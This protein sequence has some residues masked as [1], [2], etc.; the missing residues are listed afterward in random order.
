MFL[1]MQ[2]FDIAQDVIF[3]QIEKLLPKFRL[4]L[5]ILPNAAF[6]HAGL[7]TRYRT[8]SLYKNIFMLQRSL[9]IK[10]MKK[11]ESQLKIA[12]IKFEF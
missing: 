8:K 9:D 10:L 4:N 12:G 2:D 11:I 1:G 6:T 7:T 5:L 3:A